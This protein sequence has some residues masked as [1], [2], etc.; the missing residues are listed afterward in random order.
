MMSQLPREWVAALD[1]QCDLATDPEKHAAKLVSMAFECWRR[2]EVD[3]LQL[4]DMLEMAE[5]ARWFGLSEHEEMY[6]IGLF[7]DHH[8]PD[9]TWGYGL[10]PEFREKLAVANRSAADFPP[11]K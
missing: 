1:N 7:G 5:A 9:N 4:S 6:A 2:R 3:D 11:K 8:V 10:A